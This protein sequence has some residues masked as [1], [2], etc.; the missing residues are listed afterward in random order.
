MSNAISNGMKGRHEEDEKSNQSEDEKFE[1][2]ILMYLIQYHVIVSVL[3]GMK[4]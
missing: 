3:S 4:V 2:L 1:T